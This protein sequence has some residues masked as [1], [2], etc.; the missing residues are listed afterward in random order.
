MHE[1][2]LVSN[3]LDQVEQL[4]TLHLAE[5]VS[6]IPVSIGEFPGVEYE[7]FRSAYEMLVDRS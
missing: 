4:M 5:R 7:L 2:A 6:G 1:M 3:L